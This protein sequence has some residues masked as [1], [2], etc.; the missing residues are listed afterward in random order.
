[1][2]GQAP[3]LANVTAVPVVLSEHFKADNKTVWTKLSKMCCDHDCWTFIC[4]HQK[5]KN[6]Q[7]AF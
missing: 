6:G 4:Q 7:L 2:I 1:M 3:L 5:A